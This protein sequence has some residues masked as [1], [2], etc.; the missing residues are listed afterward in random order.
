[1][2]TSPNT[3]N[4]SRTERP[5]LHWLGLKEQQ[6]SLG[7]DQ[8]SQVGWKMWP[9]KMLSKSCAKHPRSTSQEANNNFVASVK[10]GCDQQC[11]TWGNQ[12]WGSGQQGS[13]EVTAPH[14]AT[15]LAVFLR[16]CWKAFLIPMHIEFHRISS[17]RNP[18]SYTC[19]FFS[20][21]MCMYRA[22]EQL[23]TWNGIL[24]CK[25]NSKPLFIGY[26]LTKLISYFKVNLKKTELLNIK[27]LLFS[28]KKGQRPF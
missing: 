4:R 5:C 14:A 25:K 21:S 10:K 11:Y 28:R 2:G 8:P 3:R 7:E 16:W 20:P 19:F 24:Y 27:E 17:C 23:I 1:M 15:R 13:L 26:F 6:S 9:N 22:S 12:G 18:N